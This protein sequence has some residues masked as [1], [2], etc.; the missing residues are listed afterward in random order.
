MHYAAAVSD[1][2]SSMDIYLEGGRG[3]EDMETSNYP[4]PLASSSSNINH[5]SPYMP[6]ETSDGRWMQYLS[7]EAFSFPNPSF[8]N[9]GNVSNYPPSKVQ[10]LKYTS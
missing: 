4:T 10:M 9:C 5:G 8:T 6:S 7:E 2:S 3:G 1:H